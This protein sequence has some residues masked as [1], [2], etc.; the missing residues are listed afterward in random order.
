MRIRKKGLALVETPKG[1]LV[2]ASKNK[3][4]TLPGGGIDKGESRRRATMRELREE[5]GLRSESVNYLFSYKG[6]R[7]AD[8]RGRITI[9]YAKVFLIKVSGK[10]KPKSEIKYIRYWKPGSKLKI[11]RRTQWIFNKYLNL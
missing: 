2:V 10:A 9:N 3:I 8:N 6:N 4:F 1:F 5:T 11:S 7:W